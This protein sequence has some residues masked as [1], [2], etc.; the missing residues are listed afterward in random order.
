MRIKLSLALVIAVMVALGKPPAQPTLAQTLPLPTLPVFPANTP[1]PTATSITTP[2]PT[3]NTAATPTATANSAATPTATANSAAT[4][5]LT[6]TPTTTPTTTAGA[7]PIVTENQQPGTDQWQIPTAG[8]QVADDT[9][10]QIKGYASATSANKGGSLSFAVTVTPVQT[11]TIA[12]YRMGWYGGLGGRLILQTAPISGMTQGPCPTVDTT[13]MLMACTWTSSYTLAV[14][15]NWTDGVYLAVLSSAQGY[16]NYVP[17]VV[18]DDARQASL[19]YQQPVNTYQAYNSWGGKSLYTFNSSG[20]KRAYKVS[21]DRPYEGDGSADYFGWEVYTVQWLEQ[22]GYD[23]TY[24][25]D[26]DVQV[27]PSR[28]TSVKSVLIPGHSE[29]WSKG[30]YDAA[31]GARDAGVSL[32]FLGSNDLY[33][34]VRYEASSSTGA[35]RVLVCYKTSESPNPVDPTGASSPGLTTTEWREAPVNRPEQTLIGVQFTSQTGNGWDNTVSYV[36]TNSANWVYANTGF[37]DGSSVPRLAGYEAD[38]QFTQY[39]LPASQPGT[40]ALLAHSPYN[41]VGNGLDY[42]NSSIYQALSG[43]WVFGSGSQ[44]WAWGLT[45]P[46]YV[47]AGI[48]QATRNILSRF[49]ST[50]PAM[51]TLTPTSTATPTATATPT[52]ALAAT[53]TPTPATG[54]AYR[55]TVMADAPLA[56]WRLGETSGTVAADQLTIR[57][58]TYA[59]APALGQPGA[60][61]SDPATSV[62][63]DGTTQYVQAPSDAALNPARFSVEVWARP[64]GGAGTYHGVMASRLYPQGWAIY[65][66]ADGSWEF[67]INSGTGMISVFGG[68][69]TLNTWQHL[70]GTF[71]GTTATLYVN[72]VAGGSGAV[73]AYQAQS[74]NPLE[75]AQSEPGDNFYFPGQL[76]EAAVYGTALSATQVQ[77]HYSVGTTGH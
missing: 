16:Q 6:P 31:Q 48:Q 74:G 69:A 37:V 72:G 34:Q 56:Y 58:G 45:R 9:V 75:I 67:W 41:S 5:T 54:S 13:T 39:P 19:L 70:V 73:T 23:V 20:S 57:N 26:V 25:T 27:N 18:R 59:N 28:L 63:F 33:W 10:N 64:T 49:I 61:F 36:V 11:F 24:D 3:A 35:N 38:R 76:E 8:F 66:A 22:S 47:N 21:F 29:Y 1:T 60:L 30:M 4:A 77:H 17:F 43:A 53:P 44:A 50:G 52:S 65:L 32:G 40:A 7:N 12:F 55:G 51:P 71:D 42:H 2:T 68:T 14:P 62:G 46:G 15:T